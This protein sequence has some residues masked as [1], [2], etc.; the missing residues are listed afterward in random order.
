MYVVCC[1]LNIIWENKP[2]N[3]D[4][5]H[6]LIEKA[7][8]RHD[9]LVILPEMFSTGFSMNVATISDSDSRE[10]QNF[11]ATLAADYGLYV[12]GGV[13]S[14]APGSRG[15]NECVAFSPDGVEI[16]RYRK[17]HPFT[18]AGESEHY[19]AG[20]A[21]QVFPCHEFKIAP[22]ICYDLRFP[23]VFRDAVRRGATLYTVIANWPTPRVEHWVTLLKARAIE[24]QA[25]VVGVNRCGDD[26]H[27][28]Y[29]GRSMII[30]PRGQILAEAG[31]QEGTISADLD[32]NALTDYRRG[33]PFLQDIRPA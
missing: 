20:G 2:A 27:L 10:T 18:L 22:F 9:S 7:A 4:K 12:V 33:F 16:A 25:Y 31:S 21:V 19:A 1:Q 29:P 14:T 24:N 23:E 30:D 26:P 28:S 13:V 11:L 15:F 5:V 3:H 17:M 6:V 32:L 8:P